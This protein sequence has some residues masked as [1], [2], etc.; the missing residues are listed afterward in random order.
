MRLR[1][2]TWNIHRCVG[3]D[4]LDIP[5]RIGAVLQELDADVIAL[6]EV[7][8]ESAGCDDVVGLLEDAAGA[9]AVTGIVRHD[10][11]GPFGNALLTRFPVLN[12]VLHDLSVAGFEPRG[13]IDTR[14]RLPGRTLRLLATHLGLRARERAWQMARIHALTEGAGDEMRV[15]LGD[16][17]EWRPYAGTLRRLRPRPRGSLAAP[18][19]FPAAR[20]IFALDRILFTPSTAVAEVRAHRSALTRIAS[21]HLPL[22]IEVDLPRGRRPKD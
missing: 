5:E 11:Q 7:G 22:V 13:L 3:S 4:G 6:Q 18:A 2:A 10:E 14:L 16:L 12:T 20:P 9:E 15:V 17:N 19:T 8:Y 21:D 1:L